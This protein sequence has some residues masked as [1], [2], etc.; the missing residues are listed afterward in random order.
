MIKKKFAYDL[1]NRQLTFWYGTRE[2]INVELAKL[3]LPGGDELP[4][5]CMGRYMVIIHRGYPADYIVLVKARWVVTELSCLSH[6]CTRTILKARC[7][8]VSQRSAGND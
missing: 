3:K 2:E 4:P 7:G 5:N 6:E 1:Y 8:S